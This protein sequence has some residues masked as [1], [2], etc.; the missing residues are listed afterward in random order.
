MTGR[1]D[2]GSGA[3]ER[4]TLLERLDRVESRQA[5][6][7][8][9]L[10]Y[11]MA[12]DD[13]DIDALVG[14]YAEDG[15]FLSS[16]RRTEGHEAMARQ[17]A[18]RLADFGPT[19]HVIHGAIIEFDTPDTARGTVLAHA[20]HMV[21]RGIVLAAHRYL[22]TYTRASG[23]WLLGSREARF[24]YV[25]PLADLPTMDPRLPRRRWPGSEPQP[26][27]LPES[28]ASYQAFLGRHRL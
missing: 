13:R 26:A 20:E 16:G 25:M 14:C 19:Y 22:D 10:R 4:P 27:D 15:Y 12:C 9:L 11:C 23:A 21:D 3:R 28:L 8:L 5:I 1:G 17:F 7:D 24:Y 2:P 6:D 18:S